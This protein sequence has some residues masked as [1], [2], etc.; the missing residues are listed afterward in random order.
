MNMKND[1]GEN[2]LDKLPPILK[3]D[4]NEKVYL[5][6]MQDWTYTYSQLSSHSVGQLVAQNYNLDDSLSCKFYVLGLHDNYLIECKKAKYILRLYRN[7]WR[8]QEEI[9]FELELLA[10]LNSKTNQVAGP[11]LTKSGELTFKVESPEGERVAAL[12]YYADGYAPDKAIQADEAELLGSAV[13]NIH[14]LS[15]PFTTTYTRT[16]LDISHLLDE[17]ILAIESFISPQEYAYL[18]KLQ[19]KLHKVLPGIEQEMDVYG[20]CIGD[21]NPTNFHINQ[22]K[23]ITLFDFD[24]CGYGYRAFEIGKFFSSIH[25][26]KERS[27]VKIAF[28]K[29]YQKKRSLSDAETKVIPYFELVSVIWVMAIHALNVERIGY[30][31]LEKSFWD[32]KLAILETLEAEW[33]N[34]HP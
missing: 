14:Q 5:N 24:Q 13:A 4:L 12:F 33:L 19:E 22:N 20:I 2:P 21:V 27:A 30:K 34:N 9:G 32:R 11:V 16:P 17:S 23:Q 6:I 26:H 15:E 25:F 8:T 31:Y 3:K 1:E 29:G 28:L 7:N 18:I 10:F